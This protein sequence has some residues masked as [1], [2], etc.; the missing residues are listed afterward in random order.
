MKGGESK[1][2]PVTR[3]PDEQTKKGRGGANTEDGN[4]GTKISERFIKHYL[5]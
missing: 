1:T 4:L 5:G 2:R 3:Q